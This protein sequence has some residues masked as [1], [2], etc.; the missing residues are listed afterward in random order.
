MTEPPPF[1]SLD[2]AAAFTDTLD[3]DLADVLGVSSIQTSP[4]AFE[5]QVIAKKYR[6]K[7]ILGAGGMGQ[8]FIAEHLGTGGDVALKLLHPGDA[9]GAQAR[10]RFRIEAQNAAALQHVNIIKVTDFG[11]DAGLLYLVMEYAKGES[12]AELI[13][14]EKKIPWPRAVPILEQILRALWAAHSSSLK[15][16]HRDIKAENIQICPQAGVCDLVK[17]L[18]FGISRGLES[19]GADTQGI[20]GSPHT[21][22][23]EQWRAQP[24]DHRADLYAV[25]CTAYHMLSGR[26]V[27]ISDSAAALG[28]LH[29][30]EVPAVIDGLPEEA[31][32]WVKQLIEKT[33]TD[34]FESAQAALD[35]LKALNISSSPSLTLPTETSA[36]PRLFGAWRLFFIFVVSALTAVIIFSSRTEPPPSARPEVTSPPSPAQLQTT[37]HAPPRDPEALGDWVTPGVFTRCDASSPDLCSEEGSKTAWCSSEQ[38]NIACCPSGMIPYNDEGICICAPGGT[39]N[40]M[41]LAN[42]C[43]MPS[44][45]TSAN[46]ESLRRAIQ[47]NKARLKQCYQH[48]LQRKDTTLQGKVLLGISLD[49]FGQVSTIHIDEGTLPDIATQKCI[50]DVIRSRVFPA[51]AEGDPL[52]L[53]Y[54]L[55]FNQP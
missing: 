27:F 15:I 33:P 9:D 43:A 42:G 8:V 20:I 55:K 38:K 4:L 36:R 13:A 18:D 6:L 51:P 25:G 17:V 5:G 54:P 46:K 10:R 32:R 48:A 12:L 49:P 35:A 30:H 45:E 47:T 11:D 40:A 19:T 41:A 22:S 31:W 52:T 21:M 7:K 50:L 28:Y 26:P 34:R 3:R 29:V 16:I 2:E 14:R 37:L 39:T 1:D 53:R 24:V 44:P 23:P